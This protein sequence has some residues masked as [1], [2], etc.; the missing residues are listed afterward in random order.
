MLGASKRICEMIVQ[1]FD[2]MIK[3]G[4]AHELPQI[5]AHAEGEESIEEGKTYARRDDS[6][7]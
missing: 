2:K 4:R 1:S 7:R 6:R 3:E 5:F